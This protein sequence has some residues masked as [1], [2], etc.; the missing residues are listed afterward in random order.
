MDEDLWLVHLA[1]EYRN[2]SEWAFDSIER[3]QEH[4]C[5]SYR[6]DVSG[7]QVKEYYRHSL[8]SDITGLVSPYS[9]AVEGV[10]YS[11]VLFGD[12]PLSE[13]FLL[14]LVREDGSGFHLSIELKHKLDLLFFQFYPYEWKGGL[15]VSV[16]PSKPSFSWKSDDRSLLQTLIPFLRDFLFD[17]SPMNL[18]LC[19]GSS[20]YRVVTNDRSF[21]RLIQ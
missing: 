20:P 9:L 8:V 18:R 19:V 2:D 10:N 1:N 14:R 7:F 17:H 12:R 6:S 15:L 21:L 11:R 3:N 4:V 13:S 16:D 5:C